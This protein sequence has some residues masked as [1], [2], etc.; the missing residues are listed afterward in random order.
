M[1]VVKPA[2]R[3]RDQVISLGGVW[4]HRNF[5]GVSFEGLGERRFAY[6]LD[7]PVVDLCLGVGK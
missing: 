7:H 1:A 6:W 5:H 4:C 2:I 3:L